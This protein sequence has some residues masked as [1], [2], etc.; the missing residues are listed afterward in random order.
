MSTPTILHPTALRMGLP[1]RRLLALPVLLLA[2]C[3]EGGTEPD[4]ALTNTPP[5]AEVRADGLASSGAVVTLDGGTSRD[6]DGDP[7]TYRWTQTGG[8][9]VGTLAGVAAPT[10]TAPSEIAELAFSLVVNDGFVDSAP[11]EVR[12]LVVR[13]R[14]RAIF[15]SR[16]GSEGGEG[17][18]EAP[19]SSL[20]TALERAATRQADVYVAGG[21]WDETLVLRSG[22]GVYGGF[23]PASWARDPQRYPTVVRGASSGSLRFA[24]RGEGIRNAT[25]DGIRFEGQQPGVAAVYLRDA[26]EVVLSAIAASAPAGPAGNAGSNASNRTGRAPDGSRGENSGLCGRAGGAGG[27]GAG[28]RLAGGRGGNGGAAGG[29]DGSRG[30]GPGGNGGAGGSTG[31]GGR[32][33]LGGDNGSTGAAGSAGVALGSISG[34]GGYIP[35]NGGT[36]GAGSPGRG[37]GGGGGGGGALLGVCGGGGG[38]GGA[39]GLGGIGGSGGQ[40]GGASVAVLVTGGSEVRVAGSDLRTAGGGRGGNGGFGGG[41]EQGGNGAGTSSA[42]GGGGG[43]GGGDGGRGG[44]GGRGGGGGGGPSIGI[45]VLGSEVEQAGNRFEVGPAGEGGTGGRNG[46][47]GLRAEVHRVN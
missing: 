26:R 6:P 25:V 43:G 1:L 46:A 7:L 24:L 3:S 42:G 31:G 20:A 41:G 10:F 16:S 22:V 14:N 15:V 38:G 40:G 35:A 8:P 39:G 21:E 13:D 30:E 2:A 19:L 27:S 11:A 34:S 36:G 32:G 17:T 47:P 23:D 9:S 18:R 5:T 37:G 33:G 45:L 12:I 4:P 29:F 44:S 28:A